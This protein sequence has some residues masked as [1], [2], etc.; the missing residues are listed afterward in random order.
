MLGRIE[1]KGSIFSFSYDC[2]FSIKALKREQEFLAK[3]LTS[4]FSAEDREALYMKWVVTL[5]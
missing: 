1:T 3:R 4:R 5:E 2:F